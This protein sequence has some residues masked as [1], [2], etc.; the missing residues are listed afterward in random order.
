MT[1]ASEAYLDEV[2]PTDPQQ[3]REL[4]ALI[5]LGT[6]MGDPCQEFGMFCDQQQPQWFAV[7]VGLT[8]SLLGPH[9]A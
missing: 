1:K 5:A 2:I 3:L 7:K 9:S 4:E 8:I 6:Q